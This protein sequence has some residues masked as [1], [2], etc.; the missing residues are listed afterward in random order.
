MKGF[1]W[2]GV[3]LVPMAWVASDGSVPMAWRSLGSHGSLGMI[4]RKGLYRGNNFIVLLFLII[5]L[6]IY[7]LIIGFN[8]LINTLE[9]FLLLIFFSVN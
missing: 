8:W 3:P 7:Q 5:G 6:V 4:S 1:S 2:L 9:F